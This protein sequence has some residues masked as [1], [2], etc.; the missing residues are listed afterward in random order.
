MLHI[1]QVLLISELSFQVPEDHTDLLDPLNFVTDSWPFATIPNSINKQ[2]VMYQLLNRLPTKE[3]LS[4]LCEAFLEN[5]TWFY[6]IIGRPQIM[7]ELIPTVYKKLQDEVRN[8]FQD[9]EEITL[10]STGKLPYMHA[11]LEES[12]RVYPP[13]PNILP[14]RTHEQGEMID[15]HFVPPNVCIT[16]SRTHP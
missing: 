10:T 3:R 9:A 16:C 7:E 6:R 12:L 1:H 4:S 11:V 14:R 13:V 8:A 15:G 5:V 2:D